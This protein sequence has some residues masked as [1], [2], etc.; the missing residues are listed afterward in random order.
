[1]E[2][3][4]LILLKNEHANLEKNECISP[5]NNVS[6]ESF[7]SQKLSLC[8]PVQNSGNDGKYKP[9][10]V[11]KNKKDILSIN[12]FLETKL[13]NDKPNYLCDFKIENNNSKFKPMFTPKNIFNGDNRKRNIDGVTI[14]KYEQ[15]DAIPS[16]IIKSEYK[17]PEFTSETPKIQKM[18][19]DGIDKV[20]SKNITLT[21]NF[22][23]CTLNNTES[24]EK[25]NLSSSSLLQQHKTSEKVVTTVQK[26]IKVSKLI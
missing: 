7:F 19:V 10:F 20:Y 8:T 3:I 16:Q 2:S 1:M 24:T 17:K 15:N 26:A 14:E 25:Q 22:G 9:T 6:D 13:P 18:C 11:S 23:I 5:E 21:G 12:D 4:K